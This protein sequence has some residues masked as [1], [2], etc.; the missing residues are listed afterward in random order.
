MI[1]RILTSL[2]MLPFLYIIHLGGV[3]MYIASLLLMLQGLKEYRNALENKNNTINVNILYVLAIVLFGFN[4]VSKVLGAKSFILFG[5]FSFVVVLVDLAGLKK[6]NISLKSRLFFWIGVFYIIVGFE[7]IIWIRN[8]VPNGELFTW[9]IFIIT[10][11]SDSMAYFTGKFFGKHKLIPSVSPNKTVEG[12]VGAVV[13]TIIA[14]LLYG[15]IINLGTIELIA[16]GFLG[17]IVSQCGDLI[18]SKLKRY[19]G[20]KDFSN[21]I[22]QHGGILDRLDSALLVSQFI[23]VIMIILM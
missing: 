5:I 8:V 16:I 12:S 7:T 15:N 6:R 4:M 23:F 10:V 22:P 13:F 9:M 20:I 18:A 3:P 19:T 14:C 11:V 17:S 1:T 2:Y 21:L